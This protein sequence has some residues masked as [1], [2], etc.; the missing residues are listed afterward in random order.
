MKLFIFGVCN[1]VYIVNFEKILLLFNEVLVELIC[2]V[3]NNGKVLFVGIKCVVF[4]VVKV[5]VVDC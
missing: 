5:V 1:G 4:E 3:S 2:I